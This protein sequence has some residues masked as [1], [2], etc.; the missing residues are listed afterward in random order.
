MIAEKRGLFRLFSFLG[1]HMLTAVLD[2][3]KTGS[4]A[5][6]HERICCVLFWTVLVS[7]QWIY[8][9]DK[10]WDLVCLGSRTALSELSHLHVSKVLS[11]ASC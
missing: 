2:H 1:L 10:A 11:D 5:L 6:S 8:V 9:C 7:M 4:H 3:N